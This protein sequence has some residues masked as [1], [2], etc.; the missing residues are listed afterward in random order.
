MIRTLEDMLGESGAAVFVQHYAEKTPWLKRAVSP[1]EA[2]SLL[3]WSEIER[4]LTKFVMP[5]EQFRVI[6]NRHSVDPRMF[7]EA[8]TGRVLSAALQELIA[9]GATFAISGISQLVP[10]IA[11]LAANI[12]RDLAER[13]N[14]NCYASFGDY[15]AFQPHADSHDV[16]VLQIAG[17]K[18][19]RAY[20]P[21]APLPVQAGEKASRTPAVWED[22]LEPGDVLYLP[23]SEVHAAL[24]I[25][26]PCVHLTIGVNDA[27]GTD[28]IRWLADAAAREKSLAASLGRSAAPPQRTLRERDVKQALHALIDATSLADYFADADRRRAPRPVSALDFAQRLEPGSQLVSALVRR[29]DLETGDPDEIKLE[30]GGEQTRLSNLARRA[31]RLATLSPRLTLAS[32]AAQLNRNADDAE[33]LDAL[34]DLARKALLEISEAAD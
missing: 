8:N 27:T 4:L 17:S 3:P 20:G 28:F 13:V 5:P 23:R 31:L 6:V 7:R 9:Q 32:L 24:P 30:I 11:E 26:R 12:E 22:V 10:A 33:L 21:N 1:L 19:W 34:A 2:A 16:L 15:S 25:S 29:I 18:R 14:I